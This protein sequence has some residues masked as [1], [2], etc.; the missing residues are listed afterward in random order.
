[1]GSVYV[2]V[3]PVSHNFRLQTPLNALFKTWAILNIGQ[4]SL[5]K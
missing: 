1:M 2:K 5:E 4:V 3:T